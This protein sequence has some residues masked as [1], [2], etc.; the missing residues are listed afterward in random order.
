MQRP[1]FRGL[2]RSQ[3]EGSN[4]SGFK[5]FEKQGTWTGW[6]MGHVLRAYSYFLEGCGM[7]V[8]YYDRKTNHWRGGPQG[9][10]ILSQT[11]TL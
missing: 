7:S 1:G 10:R 3:E 9:G 6:A 11:L 2:G 5:V 4:V 8:V